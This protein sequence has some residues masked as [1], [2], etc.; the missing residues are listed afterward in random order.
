MFVVGA[1]GAV[2]G[3]A[4]ELGA[5]G[6]RVIATATASDACRL[7]AKR[8]QPGDIID[9]ANQSPVRRAL[10]GGGV[11]AVLNLAGPQPGP[12]ALAAVPDRGSYVTIVPGQ[13]PDSQ[14][15]VIPRSL[16]LQ[17]DRR[18][19]ATLSEQ[20]STGILTTAVRRAFPLERAEDAFRLAATSGTGKI[21]L[22]LR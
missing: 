1:T 3:F 12:Q 18:S 7:A 20:L 17:Q 19:L 11:D 2:G 5:A 15:D 10:V 16:F 13:L 9:R 14:R 22:D 6:V 4:C 8:V 21:V